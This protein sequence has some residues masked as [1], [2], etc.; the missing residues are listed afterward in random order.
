MAGLNNVLETVREDDFVEYY[1]FPPIE[2]CSEKEEETIL[3]SILTKANKIVKKYT[4]NYL[5]HRDEFKLVPRASIYNSLNR[6]DG[7]KGNT[8]LIKLPLIYN[9]VSAIEN[10]PPHLYGISHY[11]DNIE[12]EWFMVFIL[13][14][15][16]KEINGLIARV[17]DVD[18]EF[19]LIES[20]DSLPQWASPDT[21]ENRVCLLFKKCVLDIQEQRIG[22]NTIKFDT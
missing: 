20:A 12:D 11:G 6:I 10:L 1:L 14:E 19:L 15:L 22:Y 2:T 8:D 4:T 21:C 9:H 18:G 16:T 7:K 13:Q 5:W 3:S 17:Y